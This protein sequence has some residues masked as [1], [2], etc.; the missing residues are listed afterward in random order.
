MDVMNAKGLWTNETALAE[1]PE[2]QF[3]VDRRK[4]ERV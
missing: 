4:P 1:K 2:P 3:F